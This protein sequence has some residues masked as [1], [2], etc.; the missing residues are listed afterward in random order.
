MPGEIY[1]TEK[2]LESRETKMNPESKEQNAVYE[3]GPYGVAMVTFARP[4]RKYVIDE[5]E[6]VK[7]YYVEAPKHIL[8]A[9]ANERKSDT[10]VEDSDFVIDDIIPAAINVD[11]DGVSA[12][13]ERKA[14]FYGVYRNLLRCVFVINYSPVYM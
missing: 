6:P 10:E 1:G 7:T 2:T 5:D 4:P 3:N 9:F 12:L 14:F 13:Q 8:Q 11:S